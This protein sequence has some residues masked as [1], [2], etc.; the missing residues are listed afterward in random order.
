MFNVMLVKLAWNQMKKWVLI[1]VSA[2][3]WPVAR[4]NEEQ[5]KCKRNIFVLLCYKE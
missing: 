4:A 2:D 1:V 5:R 3:K